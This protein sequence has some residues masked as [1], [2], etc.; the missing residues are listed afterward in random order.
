VPLRIEPDSPYLEPFANKARL[1]VI[2]G[3]GLSMIERVIE[4]ELSCPYT[5]VPGLHAT[6]V[7]GH[8]GRLLL[9]RMGGE[10]VI[11]CAG[12]HHV[13]EGFDLESAGAV[14]ETAA[15]L[16]CTSILL[17]QAAGGL[18]GNLPV[19]SW[20]VPSEI[21]FFPWRGGDVNRARRETRPNGTISGGTPL[22][23]VRLRDLV[24]RALHQSSITPYGGT[25]YWAPGP[26]YETA[27][28]ARVA[29][30]LGADAANMSCL[31][32]LLAAR[33]AGIGAACLSWI[34]N[35]TANCSPDRTDHEEV[36]R[37]GEGA[38][39]PL[40]R[41]IAALAYRLG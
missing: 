38:V 32:E 9:A 20:L 39:R 28:E 7:P 29:R 10:R 26:C 17:T 33:R 40:A 22:I 14:V 41:I 16:G 5:A 12:R 30:A 24:V 6:S 25:L 13:Y 8:A 34:T 35:Q 3:S 31:P 19:G 23:D 27:A 2:L 15:S 1:A 36:V 11:L 4:S 21:V 18:N 37:M